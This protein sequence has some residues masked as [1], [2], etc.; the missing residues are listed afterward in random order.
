MLMLINGFSILFCLLKNKIRQIAPTITGT[1]TLMLIN[2]NCE[3]FVNPKITPKQPMNDRIAE[4]TSN[5]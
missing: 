4:A 2:E 3:M 1:I 5:G